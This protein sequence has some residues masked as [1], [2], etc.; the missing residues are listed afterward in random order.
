[1]PVHRG[2]RAAAP[3]PSGVGV[4]IPLIVKIRD[5]AHRPPA[6]VMGTHGSH[7]VVEGDCAPSY[8]EVWLAPLGAYTLLGVPL[9][10]IS[11]QTVEATSSMR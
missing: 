10:G 9:D 11:G 6:F 4:S 7:S 2:H 5:S 8:L 1:M 3:R